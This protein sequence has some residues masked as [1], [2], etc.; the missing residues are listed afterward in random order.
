MNGSELE[1][2]VQTQFRLTG[3]WTEIYSELDAVFLLESPGGKKYIVKYS[4]PGR[5]IS[6]LNLENDLIRHLKKAGFPYRLQNPVTTSVGSYLAEASAGGYIRVF[7]WLPGSLYAAI[8]P[9][10]SSTRLKLGQLLGQLSKALQPFENPAAHRWIKWDP[11]QVA[12]IGEHLAKIPITWK[13]FFTDSLIQFETSIIPLLNACPKQI[14]YNDANDYNILCQWD[15]TQMEYAPDAVIDWLDAVYT[16][17]I[18][19]L[20]IGC[21]YAI[22]ECPDPLEACLDV[23]RGFHHYTPLTDIELRV[24]YYMIQARLF[25]SL[26]VSAINK[27]NF[28]SNDYLQVTDSP[29]W[30]L[31]ARWKQIHPHLAEYSFRVACGLEAIP[32]S[33]H[34]REKIRHLPSV[35]ILPEAFYQ[36]YFLLD[37]GIE[38]KLLGSYS[39]FEKS[40]DWFWRFDQACQLN[41]TQY[42]LGKYGEIRPFY[43]SAAFVSEGNEGPD[44]RTVHMGLDFFAPIGTPIFAVRNGIVHSIQD[45]RGAKNYGPTLI[46]QHELDGFPFYSLYGHLGSDVLARYHAGDTI[47]QGEIIATI[48]SPDENGGW[49]AHLHFQL[50]LDMLGQSGDFPGVANWHSWALWNQLCPDPEIITGLGSNSE[51][52]ESV[53]SLIEKRKSVL[54]FNLSVSYKKPLWIQR[55]MGAYL[56]D[57]TGKKYLDTVNNVAHCGHEHPKV[58]AA[59]LDQMQILNTNSRYL[60]PEI[61]ELAENLTK[62]LDPQLSVC[63]FTNS[64]TEANELAIRMAR[65]YTQ[66]KEILVMQWGY[67]GNS[68]GMVDLSSYKFDRK[69]GSGPGPHTHVLPMPDP[70]R[71]IHSKDLNPTKAHLQDLQR[72]LE[73]LNSQ[74]KRPAAFFVE[75]ILSCGG[76]IVYP[77]DYLRQA[78]SSIRSAGGIYI[79]DEVQTGLGRIGSDFCAYSLYQVVPDIVTFGKPLGNGHPIGAVVCTREIAAAF[80]NGMEYFNTFGGNPVSAAIANQVLRTIDEEAFMPHALQLGDELIRELKG[81]QKEFPILADIRGRGFFLGFELMTSESPATRQ[82]NYLAQRMRQFGVLISTDGPDDN[83]IK[84]K[85]PMVFDKDHLSLFLDRFRRVLREDYLQV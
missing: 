28:P 77:P 38:S 5:A 44:T 31:L 66:S 42:A 48:G 49:P 32:G 40:E 6:I 60:H 7:E 20:A 47:V 45:N 4:F 62:R 57:Y 59:G 75:S 46:I 74:G 55:G 76:Q 53:T 37:F 18:N 50:I 22:L 10:T 15:E 69:G 73:D 27:E 3:E 2:L 17:R 14:N 63:Y 68:T 21:T 82:A 23:L 8:S 71:G 34:W 35:P 78:V 51:N 84:F 58:L 25:I 79:A 81:M 12:W 83:I 72:L 24:L 29:A 9:K 80:A 70:F 65:T 41:R 52:R 54:G 56:M 11:S 16:H 64:G 85:P 19:E 33:I 30:G 67:H 43:T 36:R 13:E 1:K 39:S 26:T 61:I